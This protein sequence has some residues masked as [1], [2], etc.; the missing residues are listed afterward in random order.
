MHSNNFKTEKEIMEESIVTLSKIKEN[1]EKVAI[2]DDNKM[3]EIAVNRL[4]T[5]ITILNQETNKQNKQ[6]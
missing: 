5:A 4:D 1:L 2:I 3:L 6:N